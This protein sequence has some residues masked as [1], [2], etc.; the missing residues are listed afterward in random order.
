[1]DTPSPS[2]AG[3]EI[4]FLRSEVSNLSEQVADLSEQ[5]AALDLGLTRV[6]ERNQHVVRGWR[7]TMAVAFFGVLML[8]YAL[9]V[10]E[11]APRIIGAIFSSFQFLDF[12]PVR[13]EHFLH[14]AGWFIAM[15]L[16]GLVVRSAPSLVG[17]AVGLTALGIGIEVIQD[18]ITLN[19]SSSLDDVVANVVGIALAIVVLML[20]RLG[21]YLSHPSRM[22]VLGGTDE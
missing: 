12:L 11:Q 22:K 18:R 7:L 21:V 3:S 19:R 6:V 2:D 14:S 5:I 8:T 16:A 13:L 10:S 17:A 9:S 4:D 20:L 1:M 15:M